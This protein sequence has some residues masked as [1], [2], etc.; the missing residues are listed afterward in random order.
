MDVERYEV[1]LGSDLA[2]DGMFLELWERHPAREL[3]LEV[4]F[5]DAD[6][7]FTTTSYRTDVPPEV[8]QWLQGE[9]RRRLPPV[10][11]ADAAAV[12]DN[13]GT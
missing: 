10:A 12:A 2:R 6:G 7:S 11:D 3:A 4:F 5:S 1:I 8:E 13:G 9:A